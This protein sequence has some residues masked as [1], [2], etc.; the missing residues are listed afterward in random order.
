MEGWIKLHRK[1]LKHWV[2]QDSEYL[3]YWL[4]LLMEA[5]HESRKILWN[6]ELI[7][8]KRGEKITSLKKL[9]L[10]FNCSRE[11]VRHFLKLLTDDHMV[12]LKSNTK[13]THIS[14]CNYDSY[15]VM[16]HAKKT[17]KKRTKNGQKTES[18]INKNEKNVKERLER[19]LIFKK[20]VES[21]Q[22]YPIKMLTAFFV[23]WS[24]PNKTKTKMKYEMQDTWDTKRRLI[25]WLNRSN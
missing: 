4:F 20:E 25:T 5:N 9:A 12:Q 1:I 22:N 2:F 18:D 19:E 8:I 16:Q 7:E 23:Y 10:E 11:K 15:Q 24:E 6:K 21:F 3:K 14:I 13:Y 17:P